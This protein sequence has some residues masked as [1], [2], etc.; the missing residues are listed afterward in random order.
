MLRFQNCGLMLLVLAAAACEKSVPEERTEALT[1][2]REANETAA[3]AAN[4]RRQEVVEANRE[5]AKD[6]TEARRE[7][8]EQSLEAVKDEIEK[9]G[10]AQ[11][12]ANEETREAMNTSARV[13]MDVTKDVESRLNKVDERSRELHGTIDTVTTERNPTA[14]P[15]EA[16]AN[17]AAIDRESTSIRAELQAWQGNSTQSAEQFKA[18]IE[19]RL[20]LLE[21]NLE[22]VDDKF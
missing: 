6:I 16:R 17:L 21:K 3:E 14:L 2:Q 4:E 7:A 22:S 18:R 9:T 11:A 5:A 1:A 12:K 8:R 10:G 15:A 19:Q 13:R 20:D